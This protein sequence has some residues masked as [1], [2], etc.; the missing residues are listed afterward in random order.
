LH[1]ALIRLICRLAGVLAFWISALAAAAPLSTAL[2]YETAI[3]RSTAFL[4]ETEG[5]L[6]LPDVIAAQRAG[7]FTPAKSPVLNFGI[8]AKPVWIRFSVENPGAAPV[9][10]RLA[11]ENAWL[12]RIEL[13]F[14]HQGRTVATYRAGD[15][16]PFRQRPLVGR[17][18]LFDHD[19]APGASEVFLRVETPD[20]MVV[21][22]HLQS[23]E[24]ARTRQ[25]EQE[26]SYGIVYGFL[27]ALMAYNA[28]LY[29]SLRGARYLSYALYLAMFIAMNVAYTG[30]GYAWLWSGAVTWQ[31]WSNPVLMVL[32]G[33]SGL[34]FAIRFL[35][36]RTHFPRVYRAVIAYCA[37]GIALLA[38]AIMLGSQ[39]HA[40]L[41]SFTFV[42]L[43]TG[44][45]LGL[46]A[47][48]VRAGQK[49]ARYFLIAALA[50][51]VG[52]VLTTLSTWGFIRHNDW[53]FR[54][55]EVG[56]LA[57]ATLLAL[58]LAYQFR[59]GQEERLRAEQLAQLDPL[60]GLNNR[61]AF[62]DLTT[63]LWSNAL[64]HRHE[65]S[66]MLFDLDRF[67]QIN[68][69]YGHAHGDAVLK[70]TAEVLRQCIRQGDV[71][72]RWGGEEFIVLL[73]ETEVR[74]AAALAER[75]RAAI[76][77]MRI[78]HEGG[79]TTVTASFGVAQLD[80]RTGT[81]DALIARADECLYH[82]KQ[83][84]RNRVT[85]CALKQGTALPGMKPV[86]ETL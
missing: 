51:M 11:I 65:L 44:I 82:S 84:G 64:R 76:A 72:A 75:L 33:V 30:H 23:R 24:V 86:A 37:A 41:V 62:Y 21:P 66:V 42:F 74:E 10:K 80:D 85:C 8:G 77:A 59:V 19:F 46:G 31:Q 2:D 35:D 34:V 27:L 3:G 1:D 16:L 58:A 81:L 49:P 54:A 29:A 28:I 83:E 48:A 43:F 71:L 68:D 69:A 57:D 13:Y 73:P 12:D 40:L 14:L 50:A 39:K 63:P 26:L 9:Q 22:I 45:M 79:A 67:K 17:H 38:A 52:A 20:P 47:F 78:P 25:T 60:T 36:L 53:T 56:M 55:V 61:R 5:R 4:Q 18:F 32:Y 7:R 6:E 70:A 15:R